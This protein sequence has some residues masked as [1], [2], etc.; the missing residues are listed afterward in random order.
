MNQSLDAPE[1]IPKDFV[2]TNEGLIFA[3]VA[4]D[5][6]H[7]VGNL[8]Y[9]RISKSNDRC[10]KL[11]TEESWTLLRQKFPDLLV[12]SKTF[13]CE[14]QHVPAGR[15][16]TH[17]SARSLAQ[18]LCTDMQSSDALQPEND[19]I[20]SVAHLALKELLRCGIDPQ[21]LGVTG[22][23]LVSSQNEDSDVDLVLYDEQSFFR[24]R[25]CFRNLNTVA[26]PRDSDWQSSY[27]KRRCDLR[28]E[29]FVWHEKRKSNRTWISG[30]KVDIS[31]V[32]LDRNIPANLFGGEKSGTIITKAVVVDDKHAFHH[33]ATWII[34]CE[35]AS[36][37]VCWTATY[38]GQVFRGEQ[39]EVSGILEKT[40]C[41][42]NQI[43]V[44][45]SREA[46]GE[47]IRVAK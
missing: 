6:E 27:L 1:I 28:L 47:Y 20:V 40:K 41:G 18:T 32:D 11:A 16:R 35:D 7:L 43:V 10:Q 29:E 14:I 37:I 5:S 4:R 2:E 12:Y 8:R 9:R 46:T 34:E 42:E 3:I 44:G 21:Q 45:T 30:T 38:T 17:H 39:I 26:A 36:R 25:E 24:A 13:D 22:S 23:L 15:I 33:P 19:H 31:L